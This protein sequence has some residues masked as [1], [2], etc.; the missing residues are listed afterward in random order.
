MVR[1]VTVTRHGM[2]PC[3]GC[4]AHI[5]VAPRL[6]D[7]VCV[8]CQTALK[9]ALPDKGRLAGL[10]RSGR[11]GVIAASFLGLAGLAGCPV[12]GSAPVYGAPADVMVPDWVEDAAS[13][14]EYGLPADIQ[15][16]E[17][18]GD[19]G[20]AP[21]YGIPA[22]VLEPEPAPDAGPQPEYGLPPE[23]F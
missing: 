8:F 20:A 1:K 19:V 7:T 12:G 2:T 11:S 5:R 3:P 21:P 17:V 13:Q 4:Q 9:D 15:V 6:E 18:A 23:S 16:G 22:D 10:A 14:P